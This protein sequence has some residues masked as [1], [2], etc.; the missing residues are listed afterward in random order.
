MLGWIYP[1]AEGNIMRFSTRLPIATHILLCLAVLG[2]TQ[3]F[4]SNV[5]AGSAGVNPV[6]VRNVLAQL[7]A[8]EL[9]T[10]EPGVGGAAL[11]KPPE[12]ITLLDVFR[13]V[14][15]EGPLFHF[16]ENPSP[17]CPIGGNINDVLEPRLGNAATAMEA[18]L[19]DV[20]LAQLADDNRERIAA[21]EGAASALG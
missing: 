3:K 14:E 9:V 6:V 18:S 20:T 21:R 12:E 13:A 1:N 5:L 17:E 11:A 8:A 16:H 4:T 2:G 7:K 19:A 15:D 10:V